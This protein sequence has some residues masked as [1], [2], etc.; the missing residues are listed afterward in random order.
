M[1]NGWQVRTELGRTAGLRVVSRRGER[2]VGCT[3][4]GLRSAVAACG[5]Q[6]LD[7]AQARREGRAD[8]RGEAEELVAVR[9]SRTTMIIVWTC[10]AR[11][12]PSGS[13]KGGGE[14]ADVGNQVVRA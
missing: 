10:N 14:Q 9:H 7:P 12:A 4:C 5:R 1:G 8:V 2:G 3:V 11:A 13:Q 6:G